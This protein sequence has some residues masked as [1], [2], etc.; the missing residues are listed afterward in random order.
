MILLNVDCVLRRVWLVVRWSK[1][2]YS[3]SSND[4]SDI[5]EVVILVVAVVVV[6][7]DG[8]KLY[9]ILLWL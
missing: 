3:G 2:W 9:I 8:R 6:A 5:I 4:S 1:Y 7:V